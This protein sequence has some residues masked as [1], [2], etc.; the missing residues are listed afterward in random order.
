M[1]EGASPFGS[2]VNKKRRHHWG[3]ETKVYTLNIYEPQS[4]K[5]TCQD[6]ISSSSLCS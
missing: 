2:F 4:S 6:S 1:R 5:R 3:K